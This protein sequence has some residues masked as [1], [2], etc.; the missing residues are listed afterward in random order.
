MHCQKITVTRFLHFALM[1]ISMSNRQLACKLVLVIF[2]AYGPTALAETLIEAG[3]HYGGDQVIQGNY[4]SGA[5]DSSKAG[6][7]FSLSLGGTKSFA[8]NIEWQ[9]S[10]GIKSDIINPG[11]PEVTW[12]RY[13]VN[14]MVFY[15]DE[16]YRVGLGIT[17]HLAPKLE[18]DGVA[19]N[20]SQDFRNAIGGLFE[21]DF[22]IDDTFLWGIRYTVI[23]YK[24]SQ[25]DRNINGDSLGLLLIA[26][27]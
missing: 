15:R 1:W 5:K 14:G 3:I 10:L 16:S 2:L 20:I 21:I 17:A 8:N 12:V 13:P 6:G 18:G 25:G 26:L 24:T 9:L 4:S 22:T 7:L 23:T 27:L 19:S 11:S